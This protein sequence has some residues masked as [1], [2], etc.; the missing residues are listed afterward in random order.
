MKDPVF[1]EGCHYSLKYY[2]LSDTETYDTVDVVTKK[3]E[4][5]LRLA[6]VACHETPLT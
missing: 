2:D 4:H 3:V 5:D 1:P 6:S